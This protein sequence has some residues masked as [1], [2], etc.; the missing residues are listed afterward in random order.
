MGGADRFG[1]SSL[2]DRLPTLQWSPKTY[3]PADFPETFAKPQVVRLL[4]GD[5]EGWEGAFDV[6]AK[7]V[8][9]G[10]ELDTLKPMLVYSHRRRTKVFAEH[11]SWDKAKKSY[12][13]HGPLLEVPKD[14]IGNTTGQG[15]IEDMGEEDRGGDLTFSDIGKMITLFCRRYIS[16]PK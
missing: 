14:Y 16:F 5:S 8:D 13:P 15:T 7:R 4:P 1:R 3:L 12:Q 11:V 2:A 6:P 9:L 10:P